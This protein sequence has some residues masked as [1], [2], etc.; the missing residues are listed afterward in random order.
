M[1]NCPRGHE[2]RDATLPCPVCAKDS[3]NDRFR[4]PAA[5]GAENLDDDTLLLEEVAYPER[6]PH[7]PRQDGAPPVPDDSD[8]RFFRRIMA[9]REQGVFIV[10][11]IGYF[12]GGKTWFLHRLKHSFREHIEADL[13]KYSVNPGPAEQNTEVKGT[14]MMEIHA[15]HGVDANGRNQGF[16][17][18]DIP[19]ERLR[20]LM[21]KRYVEAKSLIAAMDICDALLVALPADEVLLTARGATRGR[22]SERLAAREIL[23][24][25][26]L[27]A[28]ELA[29]ISGRKSYQAK[30]E[31]T[32][33]LVDTYVER[34][35]GATIEKILNDMTAMEESAAAEFRRNPRRLRRGH[36]A[37]PLG[38][39][40]KKVEEDRAALQ[41]LTRLHRLI[42]AGIDLEDLANNLA[43]LV[44]LV[45]LIEVQGKKI[46]LDFKFD[47]IN[48]D[49]IER[50]LF[51]SNHSTRFKKPTL[52]VLTKADMLHSREGIIPDLVRLKGKNFLETFDI[53]PLDT[54][55]QHRPS[56]TSIFSQRFPYFKFE[57]V[58]AFVGHDGS[59]KVD[60][61][62]PFKGV[63]GVMRWMM[64][65]QKWKLLS[66]ADMRD[67]ARAESMRNARSNSAQLSQQSGWKY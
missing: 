62:L 35:P 66:R 24:D 14:K 41:T 53:D 47:E 6:D 13:P 33:Q 30:I 59:N 21:S 32:L 27:A 22:R 18:I 23:E 42:Q 31:R 11:M 25:L 44:G 3:D 51:D 43:D 34:D 16:A 28:A 49:E 65:A 5:P 46:D 60:Y 67:F 57:F 20:A 26:Q 52:I 17:I 4:I 9:L 1:A 29:G 10:L 61:G 15:F 8:T 2:L 39:L 64:W 37:L 50:H 55:D 38:E 58:S 7:A 40:E 19:G 45:S 36:R 12:A 54:V 48:A 56:L 63:R